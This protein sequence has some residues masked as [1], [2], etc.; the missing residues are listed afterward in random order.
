[1]ASV[2]QVA[3]RALTKIGASRITS[4]DDDNKAA[5]A[6]LSCF[7]DLR[8]D[9][10]RAYGWQFAL[11]RASIAA[12]TVVPDH[13]WQYQYPLPSD[14]L[15]LDT[16]NE[17]FPVVALDDYITTELVEYSHE[18]NLIMTDLE[19]PLLIR[20]IAR[21]ED[22]NQWDA[23]FREVLACRIALEIAEELTQS[24]PKRQ[25]AQMEYDK[26]LIRAIK[27]NSFERPPV[28]LADDTWIMGRL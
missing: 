20:Y 4:L 1:M 28:M 19:S 18:A 13:G 10:L 27:S 24:A 23:N 22:P 3:N 2:I 11:K 12:D 14:F 6:I 8:D 25:L 16:V 15:A 21:I 26:A 5:R 17:T 9:E 7:D